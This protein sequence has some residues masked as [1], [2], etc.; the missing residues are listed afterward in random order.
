LFPSYLNNNFADIDVGMFYSSKRERSTNSLRGK[1]HDFLKTST[2]LAQVPKVFLLSWREREK[3]RD[4][5]REREREGE[6]GR[7][8][9]REREREIA[10]ES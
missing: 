3:E 6:R 8:R 1:M 7:E 9:E 10:M 2:P 4:K 5:E